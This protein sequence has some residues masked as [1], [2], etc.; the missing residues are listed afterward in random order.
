MLF[1]NF[2]KSSRYHVIGFAHLVPLQLTLVSGDENR[3]EN[4]GLTYYIVFSLS[5]L[6]FTFLNDMLTTY[7]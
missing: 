1:S 5:S 2:I 7:K 3:I 4:K 6:P